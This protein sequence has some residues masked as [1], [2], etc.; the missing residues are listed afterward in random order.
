V[1]GR[2][3]NPV[4]ITDCELL[5]SATTRYVCSGHA[6]A[7]VEYMLIHIGYEIL[8][9]IPTPVA[10][11]LNL[12]THPERSA[13]LRKPEWLVVEPMV[14]VYQFMDSFGNRAARIQ[15][16]AGKLRLYYDN[17]I[18]D[19]GMHEPRID[20]ARLHPV[21]E[22]PNECLQFLL[23]SRYCEVDRMVEIAWDLFGKTPLTSE[24]VQA[25]MDWVHN[26]VT[27]GYQFARPTKSA[28]D[29]YTER[30]GVCRDFM[31]LSIT[32]LRAL[33]IPARYA[34]GY[35][36]DI[37]VPPAPFPMDFSAWIEVYL[38]GRWITLDA[39]HN[40]PRIGRVLQ[41]RGRD[42]VDVALTT[43]FGSA[44]LD[45]FTVWTEELKDTAGW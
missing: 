40:E 35:L 6:A 37:G 23:A 43:S 36:G 14:P 7:Q 22:V 28:F 25:V 8:F 1:L 12:Y 44:R 4:E 24:R 39:R 5:R 2:G 41:A 34:T 15:V 29:V 32:L 11:M 38:G 26:N 3:P 31:H 20:G 10:M 9:D 42:A 45:K 30:Q 21:E 13:S 17:I 33:N 16:P 19:S 18:S 27:F